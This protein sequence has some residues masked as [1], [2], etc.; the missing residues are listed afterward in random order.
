[1]THRDFFLTQYLV[2]RPQSM[3]QITRR[4]SRLEIVTDLRGKNGFQMRFR[5]L[6]RLERSKYGKIVAFVVS[7]TLVKLFLPFSSFVCLFICL[8]PYPNSQ[9]EIISTVWH[10]WI[11]ATATGIQS[12]VLA[13]GGRV[14][15][16]SL[17][18]AT[19]VDFLCK[20]VYR[21]MTLIKRSSTIRQQTK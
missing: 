9:H 11:R 10:Q 18:I 6:D 16:Y 1:M 3:L 19:V 15:T 12:L 21:S 13:A 17:P 4:S 7:L 8:R 2:Y 20:V 5:F 14:K